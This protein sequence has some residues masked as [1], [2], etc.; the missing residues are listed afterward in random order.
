MGDFKKEVL[1]I[2][3]QA[4]GSGKFVSAQINDFI[5]PNMVING[6]GEL[7]YPVNEIQAKALIAIAHKAPFGLGHETI[8]NNQVRSA[9]EID[10]NEIHFNRNNWDTFLSEAIEQS[11][12]DLGIENNLV[13][14]H[15]YKLLIY[16]TGDFF[17]SHR[18][19]EKEK[20]MFGT[21]VIT[22]PSKF[23]GGDLIVKYGGETEIINF[24]EASS[25]N[26]LSISAF[27]ADCE[28]EIKPLTSGHRICLVYNLVQEQAVN[29]IEPPSVKT[30][31]GQLANSL[32]KQFEINK[33]KPIIVLLGHQYTP[34]NFSLDNLKL[35][36][37]YKA[38]ILL[39][40]AAQINS[41]A[42]MC[43]VTSYKIGT[44]D[45][46]GG[47]D[48]DDDDDME[49]TEMDE[50]IDE[51]NYI[52]YWLESE[53]PDCGQISF[54]E[55]DLI[56]SFALD[57]NEP[58]IK[59]NSGYM[60]NYGPD[61]EHWYHY[62][63]VMIWSKEI[64][65]PFIL[66]QSLSNQLT[67]VEYL[68]NHLSEAHPKEILAVEEIISLSM[69]RRYSNWDAN[70]DGIA[71]WFIKRNDQDFF[72][73]ITTEASKFYFLHISI[74]AWVKWLN[75]LPKTIANKTMTDIMLN[76]DIKI[77]EHLLAL[78][79]S[80]KKE[81]TLPDLVLVHFRKIPFYLDMAMT[82]SNSNP[83]YLNRA[84]LQNLFAIDLHLPKISEWV[85]LTAEQLLR[86][87]Q[88]KYI[89]DVITPLLL[90]ATHQSALIIKLCKSYQAWFQK[91][92][93][94]KPQAPA[95]WSRQMPNYHTH[96]AKWE[97]LK[98]FIESPTEQN[99]EYRKNQ[100][101]RQ[102]MESAIKSVTVDLMTQTIKKGSPH[103][104]LITK[105]QDEYK[106]KLRDWEQDVLLLEKLNQRIN[107]L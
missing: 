49:Q 6:V 21:L 87:K 91:I 9:W 106:R 63:A 52:E 70:Y 54:E 26:K 76:A 84:S 11:K 36:D 29:K 80:L 88:R 89:N 22:L 7:S 18:D 5:F 100:Q 81:Q 31:I 57:E 83:N 107:E 64:N 103:T 66:N 3:Q 75:H 62:G 38:E 1:D 77:V 27:Y 41:Y 42:K 16:E 43:L 17:L 105:T 34:E 24:S 68:S 23:T 30:Y 104:L 67:W 48:Y 12:I 58:L 39:Q 40:A 69:N 53:I 94:V 45:Y 44:P 50:V 32:K 59:E 10:A 93:E 72:A 99:F 82:S 101:D 71:N 14:A 37:R 35:N 13:S 28:H 60:G 47:F 25:I 2:L 78:L 56:A 98:A 51:S 97:I 86:P 4:K 55:N 8:I 74:S 61:I 92:A 73:R 96:K 19:S 90:E 33:S 79:H 65:A 85:D 102:E 20:G 46:D 15:L 95:D